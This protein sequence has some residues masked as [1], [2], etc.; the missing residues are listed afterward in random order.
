VITSAEAWF[1]V[2]CS[3][4]GFCEISAFVTGRAKKKHPSHCVGV[5]GWHRSGRSSGLAGGGN[6]WACLIFILFFAA[7]LVFQRFI[8][9]T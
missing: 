7:T 1:S 6:V 5:V 4:I 3:R 9:A 8:P 2:L